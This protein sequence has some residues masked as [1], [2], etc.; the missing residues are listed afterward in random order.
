MTRHLL[1]RRVAAAGPDGV[2]PRRASA[3]SSSTPSRWPDA[4][5]TWCS[6]PASRDYRSAWTDELLYERRE[7]FE[8]YNKGLSLVPTAELPWYRV[9]WD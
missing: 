1:R 9:F 6:T 8:I 4:T 3:R 5:T 2:R 7:L